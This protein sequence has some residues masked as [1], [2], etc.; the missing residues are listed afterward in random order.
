MSNDE[1]T[2]VEHRVLANP[3]QDP[4]VS[5]AI[6]FN[7]CVRDNMFGPFPELVSTEKPAVY[8]QF[9]LADYLKRF[10]TKELDGKS[11]TNYYKL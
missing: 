4:R 6:F 2:S 11:L 1:Y 7:P 9:T 5:I 8:Q 3:S 10:F